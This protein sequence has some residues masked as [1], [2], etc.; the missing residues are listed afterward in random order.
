MTAFIRPSKRGWLMALNAVIWYMIARANQNFLTLVLAWG[1]LALLVMG[2]ISAFF[3]LRRLSFRRGPVA[4]AHAA[5]LMELPLVCINTSWFRRLPFIVSEHLPFAAPSL[6]SSAS[7]SLPA[8]TDSTLVR[9]VMPVRRG[10]YHLNDITVQCTDPAGLFIRTRSVF[11]PSSIIIFPAVFPIGDLELSMPET[12]SMTSTTAPVATAGSSQ[13]FYSVREYVPSDGMKNIHWKSSAKYGKLMVRE[14]ERSASK[15]ITLLVDADETSLTP[16]TQANLECI[17]SLATSIC[18]A[19]EPL[20]C[21]LTFAAGGSR[22]IAKNLSPSSSAVTALMTELATLQPGSATLDQA[23]E[24]ILLSIAPQTIVYC[25]SLSD[26]PH[27]RTAIDLLQYRG[28]RVR[29]FLAAPQAFLPPGKR[30]AWV[31]STDDFPRRLSPE[32][33]PE[34]VFA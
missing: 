26:S 34:Q 27:V 33:T 22:L 21:S 2:F 7:P 9:T 3:S 25:F 30:S 29:W 20:Q 8:R 14:Y 24:S 11:L 6:Q 10:E 32:M 13:N 28:A 5:R 1:S 17:I 19:I 4:N 16:D 12:R 23:L 18:A 31:M 15:Q